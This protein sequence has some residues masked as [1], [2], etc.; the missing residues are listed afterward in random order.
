MLCWFKSWIVL[1]VYGIMIKIEGVED[2]WD[3]K[4]GKYKRLKILM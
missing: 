1:K 4:R 2:K 3:L